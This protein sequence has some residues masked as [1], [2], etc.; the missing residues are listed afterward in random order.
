[1]EIFPPVLYS[2]SEIIKIIGDVPAAAEK[3]HR[4]AERQLSEKG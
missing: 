2:Y 1:M 4:R 3:P